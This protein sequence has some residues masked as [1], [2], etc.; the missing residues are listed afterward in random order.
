MTSRHSL[1]LATAIT[2]AL[3]APLVFAQSDN[4][5]AQDA[6][7]AQAATPATPP[8]EGAGA[9]A[10]TPATAATPAEPASDAKKITWSDLDGDKD[11]KL[12]K[13]EAAPIDKL[14]R[15]FDQADADKD[16]ALTPDEYK[17]WL[18]ANGKTNDS[19]H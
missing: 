14:S 19:H 2:A 6:T 16:S 11:G 8:T 4:P 10:A 17:A 3:A 9:M 13:T 18:A 5:A 1:I 12:S 7:S 15:V